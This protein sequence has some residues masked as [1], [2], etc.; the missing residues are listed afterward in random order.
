[1]NLPSEHQRT[2]SGF[3]TCPSHDGVIWTGDG[4]T[5]QVR[6]W[7]QDSLRVEAVPSGPIREVDWAL[8]PPPA[9]AETPEISMTRDDEGR[10]GGDE[11]CLVRHGRIVAELRARQELDHQLG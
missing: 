9:D 6:A 1:M 7:G 11:V 3:Q 4:Q 8:L 2:P 5:L 10:S